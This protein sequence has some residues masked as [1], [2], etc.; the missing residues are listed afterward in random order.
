MVSS[1]QFYYHF[2]YIIFLCTVV[3]SRTYSLEADQTRRIIIQTG[4]F[5]I[6]SLE[7]HGVYRGF[8]C[9]NKPTAPVIKKGRDWTSKRSGL[10]YD[11]T[12]SYNTN[13]YS[14]L[15]RT[16]VV[17]LLRPCHYRMYYRFSTHWLNSFPHI[18]TSLR[19]CLKV[20]HCM[21]RKK[22]NKAFKLKVSCHLG[23]SLEKKLRRNIGVTKKVG[24]Q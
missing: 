21:V 7:Y 16:T 5:R 2:I 14:S 13:G 4:S 19:T 10:F 15:A 23:S 12:Y 18:C 20:S 22:K 3:A 11:D 24:K 9:R 17:I 6:S 1:L 8:S